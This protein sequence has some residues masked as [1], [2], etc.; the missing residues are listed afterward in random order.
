MNKKK[1][2]LAI[3]GGVV[4]VIGLGLGFSFYQSHH[5]KE[6][7][8]EHEFSQLKNKKMEIVDTSVF[9]D[10]KLEQWY[11]ENRKEK[12]LY[13]RQSGD[14]TY[15]LVSLGEV[16]NKNTFLLLNGVKDVNGQLAIGYDQ[17]VMEDV[18][19]VKFEDGIRSTLVKVK[20]N[21]NKVTVVNVKESTPDK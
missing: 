20:G 3:V 5:I 1:R 15:I 18:P 4:L 14:S 17:L 19:N 12:G 10:D 16:K 21:Y 11:T 9:M 7:M 2:Y 8:T 13:L 6:N